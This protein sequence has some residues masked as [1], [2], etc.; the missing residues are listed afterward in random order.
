MKNMMKPSQKPKQLPQVRII[1]GNDLTDIQNYLMS[2]LILLFDLSVSTK[3]NIFN[4][5]ITFFSFVQSV[6]SW[7]SSAPSIQ[8]SKPKPM[9]K[10]V[11]KQQSIAEDDE[12]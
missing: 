7:L 3:T 11:D 5:K 9:K 2:D 12:A 10:K 4:E 6:D 8:P 1:R